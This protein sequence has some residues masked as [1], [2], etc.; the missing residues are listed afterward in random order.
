[1]SSLV[2]DALR[3]EGPG[4]ADERP[5]TEEERRIVTRM[6]SDPFAFPQSFKTW[7]VA[8]LEGSDVSLPLA[9]IVGLSSML[10]VQSGGSAGVFGLLPAGLF[11]NYAGD[12][13]PAGTIWCDGA[14]YA[15]TGQYERLYGAIGT[16]WGAPNASTFNVPDFTRRVPVGA[17]AGFTV[18]LTDGQSVASLRG[19]SHRHAMPHTH[20]MNNHSHGMSHTHSTDVHDHG[21][22]HTHNTGGQSAPGTGGSINAT[23]AGSVFVPGT[24]GANP[25]VT[26]PGGGGSTSGPN[27]TSTS[28][29]QPSSTLGPSSPD[30]SGGTPFDAPSYAVCLVV[31]NY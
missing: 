31:I 30:T 26:S 18:G 11:F 3:S 9:S 15:R 20:D 16:K 27:F 13:A 21:M 12:V 25:A 14:A 2:A 22:Q 29:P 7:L 1:M 8:F 19:P 10:G 24:S 17:G 4:P 6:L 5:L 23:G 28:G